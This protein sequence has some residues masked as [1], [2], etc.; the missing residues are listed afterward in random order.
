MHF[1]CKANAIICKVD[2]CWE[3]H[4]NK[5]SYFAFPIPPQQTQPQ[6]CL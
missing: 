3:S 1:V 4:V 6:S 2:L 5:V